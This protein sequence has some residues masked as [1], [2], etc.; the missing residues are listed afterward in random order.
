MNYFVQ[1]NGL[2]MLSATSPSTN[3][4]PQWYMDSGASLTCTFD[5]LDLV[6]PVLLPES[7]PIG[8]ANGGIIYA[9]HC[10]Q[11]HLSPLI[12]VHF[13]PASKVKLISLGDLTRKGFT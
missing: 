4:E 3:P 9:T 1:S 12:P 7:L 2:G 5:I 11:S 10:G 6:N 8:S 13:L